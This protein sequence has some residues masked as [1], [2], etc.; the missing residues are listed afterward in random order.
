MSVLR[1]VKT[2]TVRNLIQANGEAIAGDQETANLLNDYLA[3][4]FKIGG[5]DPISSFSVRHYDQPLIN[6]VITQEKIVKVINELKPN[7]SQGADQFHLKLIK[8]TANK[9]EGPLFIIF[10]KSVQEGV[11][12]DDWRK[13]TVTPILKVEI[14]RADSYYPICLTSVSG[15]LLEK[16]IRH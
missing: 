9:I 16:S 14:K 4:V 15:K 11:L 12:P 7:K 10:P 8:E 1:L 6:A 2:T 13:A 5:D 3:S